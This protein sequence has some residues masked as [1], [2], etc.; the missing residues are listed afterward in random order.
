MFSRIHMLSMRNIN[1]DRSWHLV[2]LAY[3]QT[4]LIASMFRLIT[5]V[6]GINVGFPQCHIDHSSRNHFFQPAFVKLEC[7]MSKIIS[8]IHLIQFAEM[9]R[10]IDIFVIPD[11]FLE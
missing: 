11:E 3:I 1:I 6:L 5:S 4:G 2:I 8:S 9:L 10:P 7:E